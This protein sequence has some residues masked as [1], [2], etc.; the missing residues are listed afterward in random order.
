[1]R[2]YLMIKRKDLKITQEMRSLSELEMGGEN[3]VQEDLH[4]YVR[5]IDWPLSKE[6]ISPSLAEGSETLN[7]NMSIFLKEQEWNSIDRH[8]KALK[9]NK[10]TW[11][12]YAIFKLMQEEQLYCFKHKKEE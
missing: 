7:K 8:T 2:S 5:P 6:E 3:T 12:K 11:I 1:M 10:S 4:S 9:L